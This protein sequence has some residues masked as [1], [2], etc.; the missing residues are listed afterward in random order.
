MLQNLQS[1]MHADKPLQLLSA[2]KHH[3]TAVQALHV[4]AS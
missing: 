2:C 3:L 4:Q 1:C